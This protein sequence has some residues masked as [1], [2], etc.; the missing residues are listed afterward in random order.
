MLNP[1][2]KVNK[3]LNIGANIEGSSLKNNV[4]FRNFKW[5]PYK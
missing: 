2:H 1:W 3:I 5:I 4:S